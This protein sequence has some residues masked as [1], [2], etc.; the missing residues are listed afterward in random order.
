MAQNPPTSKGGI[1]S[2]SL[3]SL[4][5]GKN[6]E[7]PFGGLGALEASLKLYHNRLWTAQRE[8]YLYKE[9]FS[10][11]NYLPNVGMVP[12]SQNKET[13]LLPVISFNSSQV[14][15]YLQTKRQ[16]KAKLQSLDRKAR[17]AF[18]EELVK[19]KIA[20]AK[21]EALQDLASLAQIEKK[22]FEIY[23]EAFNKRELKPLDLL[24]KEKAYKL[25]LLETET[26]GKNIVLLMLEIKQ[27][28]RYGMPDRELSFD[29]QEDC[30]LLQ[31]EK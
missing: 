13:H 18:N 19:L 25:F 20:Y 17:L 3:D 2:L 26:K 9:K 8:E 16:Q 5:L 27:L 12:F 30:I 23:Q 6:N 7:S 14:F 29:A 4:F 10:I 24:E 31:P 21:I 1:G 11:L 15:N 22:R 28:A